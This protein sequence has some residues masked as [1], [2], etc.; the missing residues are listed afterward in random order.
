MPEPRTYK[1]REVNVGIVACS[2]MMAVLIAT[3]VRSITRSDD[4]VAGIASLALAAIFFI[5][6]LLL[7][8]LR[9]SN[10]TDQLAASQMQGKLSLPYQ[11]PAECSSNR[12]P[13]VQQIAAQTQSDA[14]FDTTAPISDASIV[15]APDL[16]P[17]QTASVSRVVDHFE[18]LREK[19]PA[20]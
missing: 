11:Q 4:V 8:G 2:L 13:S 3:G 1:E 5:T 15:D 6:I 10:H 9:R 19:N 14:E 17:N 12:F 20:R 18:I 16:P 7:L